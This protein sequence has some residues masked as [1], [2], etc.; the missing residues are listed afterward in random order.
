MLGIAMFDAKRPESYTCSRDCL[1][2]PSTLLREIF[3][4]V[5]AEQ[6]ALA[7]RRDQ[8]GKRAEDYALIQFLKLLLFLRRVL[9]Q[10]AAI[11]FTDFPNS[12]IFSIAPFDSSVFR[13]WASSASSVV[14]RA[15]SCAR[16][17]FENLPNYLVGTLRGIMVNQQ[18]ELYQQHQ[19]LRRDLLTHKP[20]EEP[21]TKSRKRKRKAATTTNQ[22]IPEPLGI[23]PA[24][25]MQPTPSLSTT[26]NADCS[27]MP[28]VPDPL[29]IIPAP[30]LLAFHPGIDPPVPGIG[31][32]SQQ[33]DATRNAAMDLL[34]QRYGTARVD[35]HE[36][37]WVKPKPNLPAEPL[38]VYKFQ[39]PPTLREYWDEWTMGRN[40]YL[41][42]RELNE[43]WEA[44]WCRNQSGLKT[45]KSR[46]KKLY[47]LIDLLRSRPNW[48]LDLVWRF[49]N[50]RFPIPTQ[51]IPELKTARSFITY[52]QKKDGSGM[53]AVIS[54]ADTYP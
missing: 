22:R 47:E 41:S 14:E 53:N 17:Q 34:R 35:K 39:T 36:W 54:A 5:E 16:E 40:G 46:Y 19:L 1:E 48:T 50:D 28:H 45:E 13:D 4:W 25:P 42:I 6:A 44:R 21:Q 24:I 12:F 20:L 10:D 30:S 2:P 52:L 51:G 37:E 9:L 38:P 23:I 32:Q 27:A 8:H 43:G 29:N 33:L 3:P 11:L 26:I 49:L 7:A 18:I 31:D 15:E